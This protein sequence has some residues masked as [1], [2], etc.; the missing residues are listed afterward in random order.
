MFSFPVKEK[1]Q[2]KISL[3]LDIGSSFLKLVS[4]ETKPEG[5]SLDKF[6]IKNLSF[7]K[8]P[9][10]G[11]FIPQLLKEIFTEKKIPINSVSISLS[12]KATIVRDIWVPQMS[13]KDLATSIQY[14]LGQYIPFPVEDVFH[15]SYILEEHHITRKEGQ[16]RIVL[17]VVKKKA[18]A[19][20]L[21]WLKEAELQP[22]KFSVDAIVLANA[23]VKTLKEPAKD[24]TFALIDIGTR[25]TIVNILSSGLLIFT[26]EVG[27]GTNKI[28]EGITRGLGV[29]SIEACKLVCN[30]DSQIGGWV[31]DLITR[32]SRELWG[33]F[34][35][36]E[37]QEHCSISKVYLCGGGSLLAGFSSLL[38]QALGMPVEVWNP[39]NNIIINMDPAQTAQLQRLA[40]LMGVALGLAY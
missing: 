40:P 18:V 38:S 14:E 19:E 29:T 16:M 9:L 34:E 15:D 17:A 6:Y 1:V 28:I 26:R 8:K 25:K 33:S 27:Y 23:F 31:E 35:F 4:L 5:V 10:N 37:G 30:N 11:N 39:F 13:A 32:L 24:E 12:G 7:E 2:N 3:G 36:Y 22:V 21:S 20:R